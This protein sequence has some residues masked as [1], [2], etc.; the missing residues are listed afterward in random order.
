ML[1]Q[2]TEA[3]YSA[4]IGSGMAVLTAEPYG[5]YRAEGHL[6]SGEV[7]AGDLRA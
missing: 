7:L 6:T 2:K 5:L 1:A 4:A 3:K